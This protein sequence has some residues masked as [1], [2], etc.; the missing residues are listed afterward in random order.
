[1]P[2]PSQKAGGVLAV[3][4]EA[5]AAIATCFGFWFELRNLTL[6]AEKTRIE[7]TSTAEGLHLKTKDLDIKCATVNLNLGAGFRLN[8]LDVAMHDERGVQ[9]IR[10][11]QR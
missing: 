9:Q 7:I 11:T 1:M 3:R 8:M 2:L 6:A 5:G 10:V 4:F